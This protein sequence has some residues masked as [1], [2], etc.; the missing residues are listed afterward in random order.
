MGLDQERRHVRILF[1]YWKT[2]TL[3][4]VCLLLT[5][6]VELFIRG[7]KQNLALEQ[8]CQHGKDRASETGR[9]CRMWAQSKV[10]AKD[11][12]QTERQ[13]V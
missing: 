12:Q 10:G 2:V 7:R 6:S 11:V 5:Q 13:Q 4:E 9:M 1:N 3:H 8:A